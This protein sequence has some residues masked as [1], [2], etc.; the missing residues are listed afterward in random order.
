MSKRALK[1]YLASLEAD[2]LREQLLDLYE[3]FPQVK[4]FYDFAFNPKEDKRMEE[5]RARILKEYFP[6]TRRRPRARRS[7]AQK[8]L[9]HFQ[10]LG[11]DPDLVADLMGFNLETALRYERTRRCPDAFYKSMLNSATQWVEY[12]AA[13]G[14]LEANRQR[15]QAYLDAVLEAG[16]PF[17]PGFERLADNL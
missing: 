4:E 11:V 16:W 17:A 2:A 7:V 6:K 15:V 10:T 14:L 1:K 9:R 12:L 13:Q 5:A 8:Y 3:R